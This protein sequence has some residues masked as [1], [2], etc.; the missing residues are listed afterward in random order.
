MNLQLMETEKGVIDIIYDCRHNTG[1]REIYEKKE[2][3]NK[4]VKK[5]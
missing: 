4:E 3:N 2:K 1:I 5:K